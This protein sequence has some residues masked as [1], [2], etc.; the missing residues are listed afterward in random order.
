MQHRAVA[1]HRGLEDGAGEELH[2]LGMPVRVVHDAAH[3][4]V[5]EIFALLLRQKVAELVGQVVKSCCSVIAGRVM[6]RV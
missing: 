4:V 2:L 5:E 6:T 3:G 1:L